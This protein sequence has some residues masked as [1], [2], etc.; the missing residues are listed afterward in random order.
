MHSSYFSSNRRNFMT[1]YHK[2]HHYCLACIVP[3]SLLQFFFGF[4]KFLFPLH[5]QLPWTSC[6]DRLLE[7]LLNSQ[8]LFRTCNKSFSPSHIIN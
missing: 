2:Q 8:L 5:L 1:A 7:S 4:N 3:I 6:L